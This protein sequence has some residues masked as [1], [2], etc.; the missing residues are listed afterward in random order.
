MMN[1][2]IA[3]KIADE[4]VVAAAVQEVAV[5]PSVA[6]CPDAQAVQVP[7]VFEGLWKLARQAVQAVKEVQV[8]HPAAQPQTAA[9]LS[10]AVKT[11]APQAV[12]VPTEFE[13]VW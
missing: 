5:L 1:P 4:E 13:G 7:R 3:L 8:L 6:V 12:Q 9:V 11:P 2:I 10:A